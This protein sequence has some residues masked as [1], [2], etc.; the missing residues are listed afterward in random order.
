[1][2]VQMIDCLLK[3]ETLLKTNDELRDP[4]ERKRVGTR[5]LNLYQSMVRLYDYT[6]ETQR[7]LQDTSY[8]RYKSLA[9]V[10][11]MLKGELR[12]FQFK[13][14]DSELMV[15]IRSGHKCW[16]EL[17]RII[18]YKISY[19]DI[20]TEFALGKTSEGRFILPNSWNITKMENYTEGYD[21]FYHLL[22]IKTE[23][24]STTFDITNSD[25]ANAFNEHCLRLYHEIEACKIIKGLAELKNQMAKIILFYF[26]VE[27]LFI[28]S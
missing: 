13:F 15:D 20:I 22:Q 7:L 23:S 10:L 1:M 18:G 14:K 19:I 26:K 28:V 16:A 9:D 24:I 17:H 4:I 11:D 2:F 27:E 21:H 6:L 8:V 12:W 5:L 3:F 25:N